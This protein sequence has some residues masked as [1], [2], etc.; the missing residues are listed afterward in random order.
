MTVSWKSLRGLACHRA[1]GLARFHIQIDVSWLHL[2]PSF[3]PLSI[4]APMPTANRQN[5]Q[6]RCNDSLGEAAMRPEHQQNGKSTKTASC[7]GQRR[8]ETEPP[9]GTAATILSGFSAAAQDVG[10]SLPTE[11]R[12]K[13][14]LKL[15][16]MPFSMTGW[17]I[18]YN[19]IRRFHR[20][21]HKTLAD[22]ALLI[23]PPGHTTSK[24]R[25]LGCQAILGQLKSWIISLP[26]I[27][28]RTCYNV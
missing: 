6:G 18:S 19:P 7:R 20:Q 26:E 17:L 1:L 13:A 16:Q 11:F 5:D 10:G 4:N 14:A 3:T 28:D 23:N 8:Q 2:D 15:A 22:W 21:L 24:C 27:K 25:E 9:L 12:R